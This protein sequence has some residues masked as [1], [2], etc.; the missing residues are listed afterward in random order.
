MCYSK[1]EAI[2]WLH[3]IIFLEDFTMSTMV[4]VNFPVTDLKAATAFYTALGF[5][6]NPMFSDEKVSCMAWDE[7]FFVMLLTHERYSAFIGQKSI[8]DTKNMSGALIAFKMDSAE[9][10]KVFGNKAQQHGGKSIHLD[11][12]IPEE[13]MYGLEVEDL[14]GNCLEPVWM[15]L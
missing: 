7:T 1:G 10:V 15:A 12:G 2:Y 14:D 4:F 3:Y 5:K 8:A 13:M 11:H 9:E 6:M